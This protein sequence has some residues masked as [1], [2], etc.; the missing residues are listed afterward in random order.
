M[1]LRKHSILSITVCL[2][3]VV[4]VNACFITSRI[5]HGSAEEG[6]DD[7]SL[8]D[9][10]E[11]VSEQRNEVDSVFVSGNENLPIRQDDTLNVVRQQEQEHL[12]DPERE[13]EFN[14]AVD[15]LLVVAT[16][17]IAVVESMSPTDSILRRG[18]LM[19]PI[20]SEAK[21]S[22]VE[23]FSNGER[24]LHYYGDVTVKY[25][26]LEI[27]S[28]YMVYNMESRTVYASGLEDS[29]GV[30]MGKP[31]MVENGQKYVMEEVHYNFDSKKAKI[32]NM[33]TKEADGF[34][35]GDVLKKMPDNSINISGGTYTNCDLEEHPH[36]YVQLTT[37]KTI[38]GKSTVFGPAYLVLADV[39]LPLFLPFGFVPQQPSR[40]S[41][42]LFPTFNEEATRGF[43]MKGLGYYFVLSDHFDFTVTGDFYTMGS[44]NAMV[45]SRY[46]KRYKYDGSLSLNYSTDKIGEK[47]V[48][49]DYR[50]L[51]NFSINWNHN[52]DVKARP[53]TTFRASVQIS[54][55]GNNLYN[56][57]GDIQQGLQ[58]AASSSIS[59]SK[60]FANS[61][62]SLSANFLHSQ[63]MRD[64]SYSFTLPNITFTMSRVYPF[65]GK[66]S[67]GKKRFYE[68]IAIGY[69]TDFNNRVSFK[70]SDL[71][72][73]NNTISTLLYPQFFFDRPNFKV[74]DNPGEDA[75]SKLLHKFQ[76][77]MRHNFSISLPSFSVFKHINVSPSV[78][79]GMNWYFQRNNKFY[80]PN[81]QR[82]EDDVTDIFT[83][84]GVTQTFS[85]SL[86]ASTIL[87]GMFNFPR[88]RI[89]A[90]RHMVTPTLSLSYTPDLV[91]SWNGFRTLDYID[92]SEVEHSIQ[93]N[94]YDGLMNPPP[95]TR[96]S[97][98]M[99]FGLSNNLEAKIFNKSDSTERKVKLIDNLSLQGNYN[100]LA[101]KENNEFALSMINANMSTTVFGTLGLNF[102]ASFDP[103]A[104]D[105]LGRRI[106]EFNVVREGVSKVARLT[107]ASAA[108]SYTFSGK[109]A[110]QRGG[111]GGSPAATAYQRVY[112]DPITGEQI[113]DGWVY[114][115]SSENPWS[116]NM[117][118]SYS[119]SRSY[120]TV[121]GKAKPIHNHIQT[122]Q[123]TGQLK[124]GPDMDFTLRTGFDLS[125]MKLTTTSLEAR[126]DLHCFHIAV[127]WVPIGRM[128]Q[129]GFRIQAN[130][131]SL[132]DLL[133][134]K[135]TTSAA[136]NAG[137][138]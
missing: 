7:L 61:P 3:A 9:I 55:P 120:E 80:N 47:G 15:S 34:L 24:I 98:T 69:T 2:I 104:V 94:I 64:S 102:G 50:E 22:I 119:Y 137:Y 74:D 97:A 95:S 21:D 14:N 101:K 125:T 72:P 86:S 73:D 79:Y 103:Y 92:R 135:K 136:D 1:A 138:W 57:H 4:I 107:N 78:S 111:R 108:F 59:Y 6:T 8:A 27:K 29:T 126:Y 60:A 53:G 134:F 68:D 35:H 118:Y 52:Q 115:L 13:L 130:G 46:K 121:Q 56:S 77:G 58:A 88:S 113:P 42:V 19:F 38:P 76:N 37:A 32:K 82:V 48:D 90:I 99:S 91:K 43:S 31:E 84:F 81:T 16:D 41:G 28:A 83:N 110:L 109:G 62:F 36:F 10:L 11:V 12:H 129:W 114:Y 132:S 127:N 66:N 105:S 26:N 39:P 44:W 75:M 85:G 133:K 20:F 93:Y 49:L 40:T 25:D 96:Q 71:K 100:F 116:I 17:S 89:K 87:Y 5:P 23:E 106:P 131:S 18:S 123:L 54:S 70:V 65:R 63:N 124:L 33:R 122:V 30:L 112:I 45:T 117:S 128:Q 67:I 51:T